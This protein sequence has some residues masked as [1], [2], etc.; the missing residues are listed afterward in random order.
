MTSTHP[1]VSLDELAL[2]EPPISELRRWLLFLS[3]VT[4]AF[5]DVLLTV[6]DEVPDVAFAFDRPEKLPIRSRGTRV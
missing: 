3:S 2:F 6:D 5:V 4:P 1:D